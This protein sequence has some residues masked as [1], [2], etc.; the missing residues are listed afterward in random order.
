MYNILQIA[1]MALYERHLYNAY[2]DIPSGRLAPIEMGV[3]VVHDGAFV[4][5]IP[6]ESMS[7]EILKC[8]WDYFWYVLCE[9]ITVYY[10]PVA[11]IKNMPVYFGSYNVQTVFERDVEARVTT[12]YNTYGHCVMMSTYPEP[13]LA[14]DRKSHAYEKDLKGYEKTFVQ[15][16]NGKE[17]RH[18]PNA[19]AKDY[20][21]MCV[22]YPEGVSIDTVMHNLVEGTGII[23]SS[24]HDLHVYVS[25]IVEA[26]LV[27]T[28]IEGKP[29]EASYEIA[30]VEADAIS[31]EMA[32]V[33][34]DDREY[35]NIKAILRNKGRIQ[36]RYDILC[37][38]LRDVDAELPAKLDLILGNLISN[39]LTH[40]VQAGGS[41][42]YSAK[43]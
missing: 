4:A 36:D 7:T 11:V 5:L 35:E 9:D 33:E 27:H 21:V 20:G 26:N 15:I 29:D 19:N 39:P 37:Q 42:E 24:E 40:K 1:R 10:D 31:Y 43:R 32:S 34:A 8:Y 22:V 23:V 16:V 28:Y 25:P 18:V 13:K 3:N 2:I 41:N 14:C 38:S 6:Y 17:L 12:H 30:H